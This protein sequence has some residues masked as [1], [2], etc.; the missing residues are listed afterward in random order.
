MGMNYEDFFARFLSEEYAID[1]TIDPDPISSRPVMLKMATFLSKLNIFIRFL[2][3]TSQ[4][5]NTIQLSDR[6][7]YHVMSGDNGKRKLPYRAEG[8]RGKRSNNI[9]NPDHKY[10]YSSQLFSLGNYL[11]GNHSS[12]LIQGLI[13]SALS[14][15][16][17]CFIARDPAQYSQVLTQISLTFSRH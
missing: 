14:I 4:I 5:N 13:Q 9:N 17:L 11:Q 2:C 10:F 3:L 16:V 7:L 8:L 12:V 6:I 15:P 1:V